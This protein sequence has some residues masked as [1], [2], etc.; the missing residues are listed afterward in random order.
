MRIPRAHG[1]SHTV[2]GTELSVDVLQLE[3]WGHMGP[4][5]SLWLQ[6][7]LGGAV[8]FSVLL[9]LEAVSPGTRC[10]LPGPSGGDGAFCLL[11]QTTLCNTSLDNPTQRNKDQLIQAAVK[12]L[13][14]DTIW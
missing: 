1:L 3:L 9:W 2:C 6:H 4:G 12:F 10:F 11:I 8:W 13:D 7:F 14:T 5:A